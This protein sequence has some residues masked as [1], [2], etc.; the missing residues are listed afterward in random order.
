MQVTNVL[1]AVLCSAILS[2]GL[3]IGLGVGGAADAAPGGN[4]TAQALKKI[5]KDLVEVNKGIASVNGGVETANDE[6]AD[7]NRALG[8][9]TFLSQDITD[10]LRE[11]CD[12]TPGTIC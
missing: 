7:V 5:H 2:A 11:I 8:Q 3:A 4:S 10:L 12:N 6:L 9:P 1:V